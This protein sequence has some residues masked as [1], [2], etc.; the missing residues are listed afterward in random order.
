METYKVE[1]KEVSDIREKT[2]TQMV[3]LVRQI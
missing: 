3:R 2:Y 1:V